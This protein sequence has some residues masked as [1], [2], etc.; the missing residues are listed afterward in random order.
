MRNLREREGL[1]IKKLAPELKVSY[2]YLSKL[3]NNKVSPSEAM[4]HRVAKYFKYSKD[5]MLLAAN[6][7][8]L[9]VLKILKSNPEAAI[10]YLRKEFSTPGV[11]VNESKLP[12]NTRKPKLH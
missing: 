8:P 1:G 12:P 3:E 9:D 5:E 4:V 11:S 10:E 7:V 2:S 6:R